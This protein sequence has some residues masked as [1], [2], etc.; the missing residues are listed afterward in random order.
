MRTRSGCQSHKGHS[1]LSAEAFGAVQAV[2]CK[3]GVMHTLGILNK[4]E[5]PVELSIASKLTDLG[6]ILVR[7]FSALNGGGQLIRQD[8]QLLAD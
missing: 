3:G 1:R 7:V 5:I 2:S 8:S 6:Q 4:H